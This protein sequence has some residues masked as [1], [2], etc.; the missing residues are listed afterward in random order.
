LAQDAKRSGVSMDEANA[1]QS[2]AKE[3]DLSFRGPEI[4]PNRP[5]MN[6][7]HIHVGS[8]DHIP[9]EYTP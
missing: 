9:V 7:W 3:Y 6:F 5:I 1:L 2:W 4:H 8:V